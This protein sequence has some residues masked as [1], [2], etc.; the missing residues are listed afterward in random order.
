MTS[1]DTSTPSPATTTYRYEGFGGFAVITLLPELNKV[2]WAD[3]DTIGTKLLGRMDTQRTPSFLIDLEALNYMGSAMV[4]LVVRLWK[5]VKERNGKMAVVN[6][7]DMV[8]EV[9]KLAGLAKVWTIVDSREAGFKALG[10][11]ERNQHSQGDASS[12]ADDAGAGGGTLAAVL[13]FLLLVAGGGGLFLLLEPQDFVKDQRMA[14]GAMFGGCLLGLIAAT[15]AAVSGSGF[16]R[17]FGVLAVLASLGIIGAA[18]AKAPQLQPVFDLD[19]AKADKSDGA[20]NGK[21]ND[22]DPAGKVKPAPGGKTTGN[23][24]SAGP[25]KTTIPGSGQPGPGTQG[26]V[27]PPKTATQG[28]PVK[29]PGGKKQKKAN[30]GSPTATAPK[31]RLDEDGSPNSNSKTKKNKSSKSSSTSDSLSN[32][33][34][35]ESADKP[36]APAKKSG[37]KQKKQNADSGSPSANAPKLRLDDGSSQSKKNK[38]KNKKKSSESNSKSDSLSNPS[39]AESADKPKSPANN[40]GKKPSSAGAPDGNR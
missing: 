36:E 30:S 20:A 10:V 8:L 12:S 14:L 3:I 7:D 23:D 31:L 17:G 13:A 22:D 25:T 19:G 29:K 38:S 26:P 15:A 4:A 34:G 27:G 1:S 16:K 39:G 32:P 6:S 24:N 35:A 21:A 18:F 33:S 11:S 40:G 2:P 28:A 37:D 5:S 9:L